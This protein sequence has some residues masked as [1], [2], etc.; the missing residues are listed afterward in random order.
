MSSSRGR[1]MASMIGLM[2][3]LVGS[4]A[5]AGMEAMKQLANSPKPSSFG[6]RYGSSPRAYNGGKHG[7]TAA[8][9]RQATRRRN[10]RKHNATAHRGA[11]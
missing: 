8:A 1:S 5:G 11:R 10:I 6:Q 3:G 2:L 4:M 7:S 9:K